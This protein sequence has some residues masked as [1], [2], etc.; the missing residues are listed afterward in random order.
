MSVKQTDAA[1]STSIYCNMFISN[2]KPSFLPIQP[3]L[4]HAISAFL[5]GRIM[6]RFDKARRFYLFAA[7][8]DCTINL[9]REFFLFFIISSLLHKRTAPLEAVRPDLSLIYFAVI[10]PCAFNSSAQST[11]PPAAPRTVLCDKPTNFQS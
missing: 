11:A 2:E 6:W 9:I 3:I 1:L 5:F 4:C 7:G 10:Y 8:I